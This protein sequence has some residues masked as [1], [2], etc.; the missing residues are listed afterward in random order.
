MHSKQASWTEALLS[1]GMTGLGAVLAAAPVALWVAS[2][3]PG[4]SCP[5][6]SWKKFTAFSR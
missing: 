3:R 4:L 6:R 5:T 2:P 1:V